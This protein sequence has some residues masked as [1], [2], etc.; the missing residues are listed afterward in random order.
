M[1]RQSELQLANY[2]EMNKQYERSRKV[3][4]DI[5]KHLN[6]LSELTHKDNQKTNT[7]SEMIKKEV[8]CTYVKKLYYL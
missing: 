3:I 6:V 1:K 8:A 7:Y 2:T 5:K 4:H